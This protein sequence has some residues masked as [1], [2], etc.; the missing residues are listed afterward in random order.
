[1]KAQRGKRYYFTLSLTSALDGV[2]GQR[3]VPAALFPGNETRYS[4]YRRLGGP[5]DRSGRG[6]GG[7]VKSRPNRDSIPRPSS[8]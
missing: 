6:G 2:S 7:G 3:H 8:P 5:Q 4:L 1:M